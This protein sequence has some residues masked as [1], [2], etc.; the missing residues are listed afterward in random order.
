MLSE[1]RLDRQPVD[2][3]VFAV[4]AETLVGCTHTLAARISRVAILDLDRYDARVS[5][6]AIDHPFACLWGSGAAQFHCPI[7]VA[8]LAEPHEAKIRIR[9][10]R[11]QEPRIAGIWHVRRD[12]ND[13]MNVTLCRRIGTAELPGQQCSQREK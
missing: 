12:V 6:H 2:V 4:S 10:E 11:A 5:A 7:A 9:H 8:Q 13:Q 3:T 1:R